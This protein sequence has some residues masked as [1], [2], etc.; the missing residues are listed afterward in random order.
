MTETGTATGLGGQSAAQAFGVTVEAAS[1]A[2][3]IDALV[4]CPTDA[5]VA[6][7]S[8]EIVSAGGSPRIHRGDGCPVA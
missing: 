5:E 3:D 2:P 6:W 7:A 1:G 4:A 8:A